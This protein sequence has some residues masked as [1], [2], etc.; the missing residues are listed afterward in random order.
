MMIATTTKEAEMALILSILGRPNKN[1]TITFPNPEEAIQYM[2]GATNEVRGREC[3]ITDICGREY[4]SED[5]REW[6]HRLK[7]VV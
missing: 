2:N 5:Q 4:T 6:T 3:T 1:G 7:A